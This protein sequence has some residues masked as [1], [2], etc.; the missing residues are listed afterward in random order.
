[1][2]IELTTIHIAQSGRVYI[3]AEDV[4]RL[5]EELVATEAPD[6]RNRGNEL[7]TN[8]RKLKAKEPAP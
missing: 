6:V 1:V 5:I 2:R 3:L 7:A 8:V 4:A